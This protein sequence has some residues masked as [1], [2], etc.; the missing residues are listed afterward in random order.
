MDWIGFDSIPHSCNSN[1]LNP[2]LIRKDVCVGSFYLLSFADFGLLFRQEYRSK[3]KKKSSNFP[4]LSI[5]R[6]DDG[7]DED[8]VTAPKI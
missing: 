4:P 5:K 6:G 3:S 7:D 8:D 2:K 1:G